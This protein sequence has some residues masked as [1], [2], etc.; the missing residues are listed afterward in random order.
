MIS[1]CGSPRA[2]TCVQIA[3]AGGAK[4]DWPAAKI[5]FMALVAGAYISFGCMLLCSVGGT[6]TALGQARPLLHV[7]PMSAS[8][9]GTDPAAYF[10]LHLIAKPVHSACAG[11]RYRVSP[12]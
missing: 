10:L 3:A 2:A 9:A 5:F 6:A 12:S 7:K 4:A 1:A 11:A 8:S